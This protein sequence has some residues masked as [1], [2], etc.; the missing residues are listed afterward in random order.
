MLPFVTVGAHEPVDATGEFE[1]GLGRRERV[2]VRM[3]TT[4]N[5]TAQNKTVRDFVDTIHTV[6]DGEKNA[7]GR[8][9]TPARFD[10]FVTADAQRWFPEVQQGA[11]RP[12]ALRYNSRLWRRY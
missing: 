2:N 1:S 9:C 6:P 8:G 10:A 12:G 5:A 7:A 11:A 4:A 3:K